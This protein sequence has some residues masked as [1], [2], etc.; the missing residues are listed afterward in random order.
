MKKAS[1]LAQ[2]I[3]SAQQA[4]ETWHESRKADIHLEGCDIFHNRQTPDQISNQQ[5]EA[6][7]SKKTT[8]SSY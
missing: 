8:T 4:I 1:S 6:Q 3:E 5:V 2:Q 7:D